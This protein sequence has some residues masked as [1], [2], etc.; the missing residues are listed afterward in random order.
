MFDL[1]NFI[2]IFSGID[3]SDAINGICWIDKDLPCFRFRNI[4]VLAVEKGFKSEVG[5]HMKRVKI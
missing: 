4:E 5:G 1:K 2:F 3:C